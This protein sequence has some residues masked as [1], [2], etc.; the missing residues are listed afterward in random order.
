MRLPKKTIVLIVAV[1][2]AL[3]GILITW[4]VFLRPWSVQDLLLATHLN[5]GTQVTLV[6]TI[7]NTSPQE[8]SE[9]HQVYLELDHTGSRA[10]DMGVWVRGDPNTTYRIGDRFQTTLH[11]TDYRFNGDPAVWAPE[12]VSP[13]PLLLRAISTVLDESSMVSGVGLLY[14]GRQPTG[15]ASYEVTTR[16]GDAYR[17]DVLPVTLRKSGS[18]LSSSPELQGGSIDSVAEWVALSTIQYVAISGGYSQFPT[19]DRMSSLATGI[20]E[21]GTMRFIDADANGLVNDGD[22]LEML[23]P[24]TSSDSTFDTYVLQVGRTNGAPSAYVSGGLLVLNGAH[25]PFTI[26]PSSRGMDVLHLRYAGDVVGAGITT[27]LAVTE[28]RYGSPHPFSDLSYSFCY[29]GAIGCDSR[30]F[31]NLP[32]TYPNGVALRFHDATGNG[33]LD[34]GDWFSASGLVNQSSSSLSLSRH[35]DGS[36]IASV[37]WYAG[38]GPVVGWL[39]QFTLAPDGTGPWR[40]NVNVPWWHPEMALNLT[41]R[42]SMTENGVS[43]VNARGI[44]G[45]VLGT[46]ANGSLAFTDVDADGMLSTGDYFTANGSLSATYDLEVSLLFGSFSRVAALGS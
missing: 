18:L 4:V 45:G 20:S 38:Y 12:L 2:I 7:T 1:V 43:V 46:F 34:A 13:F 23:L 37:S 27:T 29:Q 42:V 8:T 25:G 33:L 3:A 30:K 40:V 9:G 26:L 15:W 17:P 10:L 39:P 6:G 28:I 32:T 5:P 35:S 19:T 21:N 11:F 14:Q 41:L 36:S 16:T 24:P 44:A 31:D 22:R